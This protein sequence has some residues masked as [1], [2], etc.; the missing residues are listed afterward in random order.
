ML[1]GDLTEITVPNDLTAGES[2]DEY[3][4]IDLLEQLL[5]EDVG[6]V[7]AHVIAEQLLNSG[8]EDAINDD[9]DD[10]FVRFDD[11]D[12]GYEFSLDF[13]DG[14]WGTAWQNGGL[15]DLPIRELG[16]WIDDQLDLPQSIEEAR[17]DARVETFE[18]LHAGEGA[19]I[20]NA[21]TARYDEDAEQWIL[22]L[23][24]DVEVRG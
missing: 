7:E 8:D 4:K 14:E 11:L 23:D 20:R 24:V 13:E 5:A 1:T 18:F 2:A 12:D 19:Q 10:Q 9:S 3:S 6:P 21:G 22:D 16:V 15:Y 17:D